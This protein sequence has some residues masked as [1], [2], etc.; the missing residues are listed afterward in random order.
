MVHPVFA[1]YHCHQCVVTVSCGAMVHPQ[2]RGLV[3]GLE[4]RKLSK[5]TEEKNVPAVY[6]QGGELV[7]GTKATGMLHST[8]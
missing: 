4:N 3:I 1:T 7:H 2:G 8:T 5:K 6:K